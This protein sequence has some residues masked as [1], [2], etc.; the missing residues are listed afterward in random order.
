MID[1]T[2]LICLFVLVTG[3]CIGSFLNVVALR[4]LSG[5]SIV[6]PSS[7]CPLCNEPIK[8]YDNIPVLSYLFT[9]RGKC[10]NCGGKVSVQYPI[11]EAL[12]SIL[13]LLIFLFFGISLKTLFLLIM[14][15]ISIVIGI[16]DFKKE[17]IY[18]VHS[19]ILIVSA[20]ATSLAMNGLENYSKPAIG[21][22]VGVVLMEGIA[23]ISYYLIRK[24]EQVKE[25]SEEINAEDTEEEVEHSEQGESTDANKNEVVEK[26]EETE[27]LDEK[28]E[29]DI[30]INEYIKQNKRAFGEGDTYLAA[31]AG[32]LLG[33][34]YLIVAVAL[35][36]II[37]AV[38]ILP[39]FLVGLYKQNEK[40]L[41]F[42][43]SAF[44]I[45]A[46]LYWLLSNAFELH[47]YV[48]FAFLICLI[49]FAIDSITRLKKTVN[50]QGFVSLPFGPALLLS[51][52]ATL[53]FGTP[54]VI[55]ILKHI[56]M[57]AE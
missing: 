4:A 24:D 20:I 31:A 25:P 7:K 35:A 22:I 33:W 18:D 46:I 30:D 10:R 23:K 28:K 29:E 39:Q 44:V 52:Y 56:F 38:C 12:T 41:L 8:W 2:I 21:L 37:Q 54:I 36:I 51:M 3:A 9:F 14:V 6:F 32:A 55:F 17:C 16:T 13:F 26:S 5:E 42:S 49:F 50:Q 34:Q 45:I 47:L 57:F 15:C 40:R 27:V 48:I 11:V 19:W 53:F 43:L 1:E